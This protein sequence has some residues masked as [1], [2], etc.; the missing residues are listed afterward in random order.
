[1]RKKFLSMFIAL[2]MLST[3]IPMTVSADSDFDHLQYDNVYYCINYESETAYVEGCDSS[4]S[5][6]TVRDEINGYPVTYIGDNAFE[7]HENL[8]NVSLSNNI[9]CI[10][11]CAFKNCSTLSNII[12]PNSVTTILDRAFSGCTKLSGITIPDSVTRIGRVIFED[13]LISQNSDNWIDGILYVDNCVV[14]SK[15]DIINANIKDGTR[16][17]CDAAFMSSNL[18]SVTI[19]DSVVA[20]SDSAFMLSNL[21]SITIPDSV[22]AIYDYAFFYCS[23]LNNIKIGNGVTYIGERAFEN[24]GYCNNEANWVDDM[25]YIDNYLLYNRNKDITSVDIKEGT[26]LLNNSFLQCEKLKN[27]TLPNSIVALNN[28]EFYGCSSLTS[29]VL[30]DSVTTVG[31]NVF[32]ACTNLESM[33]LSKNIEVLPYGFACDCISLKEVILPEHLKTI[34]DKAF[35]YTALQTVDMP[36]EIESLSVFEDS[37]DFGTPNTNASFYGSES[38]VMRCHENSYVHKTAEEYNLPYVLIPD[39]PDKFDYDNHKYEP[40]LAIQCANFAASAYGTYRNKPYREIF[41]QLDS[42]DKDTLNNQLYY[43]NFT[44]SKVGCLGDDTDNDVQ[45]TFAHKKAIYNGEEKEITF[46]ILRGVTGDSWKEITELGSD[47]M[48]NHYAFQKNSK[49]LQKELKQYL[50][51]TGIENS[52]VVLTGHSVGGAVANLAAHDLTINDFDGV[53]KNAIYAY[54]FGAPNCTRDENTDF[55]NIYNITFTDDF[56]SEFPLKEWGYSKYGVSYVASARS[57]YYANQDFANDINYVINLSTNRQAPNFNDSLG[58]AV[59]NALKKWRNIDEYYNPT[60]TTSPE[61]T[62]SFEPT[63]S[64]EPTISPAPLPPSD[65]DSTPTPTPTMTPTPTP[66]PDLFTSNMMSEFPT[67]TPAQKPTP[68]PAQAPTENVT[69]SAMP[70]GSPTPTGT[71]TPS[72][73]PTDS[74]T[75]TETVAPSTAP[76]DEP[77]PTETVAPSATPTDEPTSLPTQ[78]PT[79]TSSPVSTESPNDYDE[80]DEIESLNEYLSKYL[81]AVLSKDTKTLYQMSKLTNSGNFR[82]LHNLLLEGASSTFDDTH[83]M[84]TYY[85]ALKYN[86]FEEETPTDIAEYI[87]PYSDNI[88]ESSSDDNFSADDAETLKGILSNANVWDLT[89]SPSTWSCVTWEKADDG[90]YYCT[91]L[92]LKGLGLSGTLDVSALKEL[93]YLNCSDNN[94]DVVNISN[95]TKLENAHIAHCPNVTIQTS[96]S[97]GTELQS[98]ASLDNLKLLEYDNGYNF[99]RDNSQLISDILKNNNSM[100]IQAKQSSEIE[101]TSPD[102]TKSI[103]VL[104]KYENEFTVTTTDNNDGMLMITA[105][106]IG[107]SDVHNLNMYLATYENGKLLNVNMLQGSI[108]NNT[109]SFAADIPQNTEYKFMLWDNTQ[110]PIISAITNQ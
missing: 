13:T 52:A 110:S 3:F 42:E 22:V 90:I 21:T 47:S 89:A 34:K 35:G 38:V 32:R 80:F 85:T 9:T 78:T 98:D 97:S 66:T 4:V 27:I 54:T 10:G 105:T 23:H 87:L 86:L 59:L 39:G 83:Q 103:S 68:T 64:P 43:Y 79:S 84:Y 67:P 88:Q 109:V 58:Y 50:A 74:P 17:I 102:N 100:F 71:V 6:I 33:V 56:V 11:N 62:I 55:D 40:K 48:V 77:T 26:R 44:D 37:Y 95:C 72:A 15:K 19:P 31:E 96:D 108:K 94:Y 93:K 12:I 2:T 7:N 28:G 60:P 92:D 101:N 65:A 57:S 30:P 18:T 76:T 24:I 41:Y 14:D 29:I 45:Y 20:I 73:V 63:T 25:L 49:K 8:S 81:T 91:S 104:D 107:N 5:D 46:V 106:N 99:N 82:D 1:M 61:P 69:P 70:T 75:P 51:D 36:D 53:D 16:I